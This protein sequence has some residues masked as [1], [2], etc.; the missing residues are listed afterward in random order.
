VLFSELCDG[1]DL[2]IPT[3]QHQVST[4][5]MQLN[6]IVKCFPAFLTG[7]REEVYLDDVIELIQAFW[8]FQFLC[9]LLQLSYHQL[10]KPQKKKLTFLIDRRVSITSFLLWNHITRT[11]KEDRLR[12]SPQI[13]DFPTEAKRQYYIPERHYPHKSAALSR[14][15]PLS[16]ANRHWWWPHRD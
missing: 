8:I 1:P 13:S 14:K 7:F 2:H 15:E 16:F 11:V 3:F 4:R 5:A 10:R 9:W 12:C 6:M